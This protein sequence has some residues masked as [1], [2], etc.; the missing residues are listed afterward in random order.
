MGR[1]FCCFKGHFTCVVS[2]VKAVCSYQS[3]V[4]LLDEFAKRKDPKGGMLD[5][6]ALK[7]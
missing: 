2:S 6:R 5:L 3:S 1:G 7:C 4:Y